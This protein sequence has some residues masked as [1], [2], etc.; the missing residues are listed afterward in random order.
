MSA[1]LPGNPVR[2]STTGRPVMALLDLLGRRMAL[3]VLWE[4]RDERRTFRGLI[5]AAETNP[6]VLNARLRELRTAGLIGHDGSG[7]ALTQDGRSLL[8][9]LLP[10][11]CWSEDW[12]RR[13]AGEAAENGSAACLEPQRTS[14]A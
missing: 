5:E 8:V 4:L 7:Y 2:G 14:P 12:G 3:R 10:I 13:I 9:L 1:P 6:A 11:M